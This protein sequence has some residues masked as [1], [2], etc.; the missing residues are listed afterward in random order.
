MKKE[1]SI[2]DL[3]SNNIATTQSQRP[4]CCKIIAKLVSFF[5]SIEFLFLLFLSC[6]NDSLS[7]F[8]IIFCSLSISISL[9]CTTF[10][11]LFLILVFTSLCSSSFA[12]LQLFFCFFVSFFLGFFCSTQNPGHQNLNLV[13]YIKKLLK[14][15]RELT[16]KG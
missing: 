12:S 6:L 15:A 1:P 5:L 4:N 16:K 13:P 8:L 3:T 7:L 11:P 2:I 14:V 10:L 9:S